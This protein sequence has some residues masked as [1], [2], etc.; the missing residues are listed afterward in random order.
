MRHI[1]IPA[2]AHGV[3]GADSSPLAVVQARPGGPAVVPGGS[4]LLTADFQ[5]VGPNLVLVAPDGT[6]VVVVDYFTL[7]EPPALATAGGAVLPSDLV[8]KLA[9]PAAAGAYAEAA[10][11][12]AS[13]PIGKVEKLSGSVESKHPDGTRTTLKAGDAIFQ[14]D[15]LETKSDGSVGVV[16][17]DRTTFSL[18]ANGRMVMDEMV[19][20]PGAK[21][22]HST[23]S[24]VQGAFS[25]VSG[26]IAKSGTD[27]M[28][29]RTP[30]MTIGIRGTSGAGM[31]GADGE[32]NAVTLMNDP[33]GSI[34]QI[35]V[36]NQAGAQVLS[37]VNQ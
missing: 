24:V 4:L 22:G 28:T 37:Q 18:G 19:Y 16:F 3:A 8:L 29:I 15:V 17:A 26:Q 30:V 2:Q 35:T 7:A 1:T 20:D 36:A 27:A 11:T 9:G 33:D 23:F 13:P 34:G 32:N 12:P 6:Q 10:A 25:F 5:R 31:A 21:K 14:G